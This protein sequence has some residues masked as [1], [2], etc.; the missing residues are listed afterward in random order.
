M[1]GGGGKNKG[2]RE[3]RRWLVVVKRRRQSSSPSF[4]FPGFSRVRLP[5][6]LRSKQP[7]LVDGTFMALAAL[8]RRRKRGCVLGEKKMGRKRGNAFEANR[9]SS[10]FSLIEDWFSLSLAASSSSSRPPLLLPRS[11]TEPLQGRG[12]ASHS[13]EGSKENAHPLAR[14]L[15][16][17]PARE[18][19]IVFF[20][21]CDPR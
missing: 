14:D 2:R 17:A 8:R 3:R 1:R 21:F 9:R 11:T 19:E 7:P 16:A 12:A 4:F 10:S 18:V 6:L 5:S 15:H 20:F 13:K